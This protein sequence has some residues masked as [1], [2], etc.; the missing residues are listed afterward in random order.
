MPNLPSITA[1]IKD[2]LKQLTCQS[3]CCNHID[4]IEPHCECSNYN[5]TEETSHRSKNII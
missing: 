5:A 1:T 4:V 3:S 2:F